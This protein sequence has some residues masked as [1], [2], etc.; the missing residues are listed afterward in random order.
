MGLEEVKEEIMNNA[1]N[2]SNKIIGEA[3]KEADEIMSKARKRINDYKKKLEDDKETLIENLEKMKTAQARSEAKKLVLD[4]KKEIINTVFEKAKQRL[5]SLNDGEKK[6]YIQKLVEKAKNEIDAETVY[7][8]EK[9]KKFLNGLR[10]EEADII[11]G[12][13]VE[14]KDKTI[15]I[16]YSFDTMLSNIKESSLQEIAKRL[17]S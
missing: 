15:R 3:K 2:G 5:L 4:K 11:G 8:N 12:I 10:C 17:F 9:D 13:I 14:N 6:K 7:C 1:R 16:D